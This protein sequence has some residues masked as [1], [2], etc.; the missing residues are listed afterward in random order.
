M[1]IRK[2]LAPVVAAALVLGALP[3]L[4]GVGE[5]SP[6][7]ARSVIDEGL[8]YLGTPYEFGSDRGNTRTFDCSDFTRQA[9]R[10]GADIKLPSDSRGQAAFVKRIGDTK[11]RWENLQKGDLMFFMSYRGSDS[12]D[13]RDLDRDDRRVTHVGIYMGNGKVLHTFSD[14]DG[15]TVSKID[16]THWEHRFLFGGSAIR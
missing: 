10:D 13:Y 2:A 16:G 1:I 12:D 15:V 4:P 6:A 7:I 3:S 11:K 8:D 14:D 5:A 9:F